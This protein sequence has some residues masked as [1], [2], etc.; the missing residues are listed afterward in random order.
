MRGA[1]SY[2]RFSSSSPSSPLLVTGPSKRRGTLVTPI[3]SRRPRLTA[4]FPSTRSNLRASTFRLRLPRTGRMVGTS[5]TTRTSSSR[6]RASPSRTHRAGFDDPS[7]HRLA[8]AV[9]LP[10]RAT[11]SRLMA[12]PKVRRSTSERS[13]PNRLLSSEPK[14]FRLLQD[15]G[16]TS[17]RSASLGPRTPSRA[18]STLGK[19]SPPS[20]LPTPVTSSSASS[21]SPRKKSPSRFPRPSTSSKP[22]TPTLTSPSRRLKSPRPSLPQLSL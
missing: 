9:S 22:T 5:S 16:K 14:S 10:R 4:R 21:V 6:H 11:F 19:L 1:D 20:S 8:L 2:C 13:S 3:S 17:A 15:R 7:Q 12:R 18:T